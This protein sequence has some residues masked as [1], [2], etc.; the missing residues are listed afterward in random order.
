[1][2]TPNVMRS[3]GASTSRRGSGRG[4]AGSVS[5]SPIV[6][7][8]RPATDDDV[9]RAGLGDV[10][11]VDAVGRLEA[12]HRAGERHGPARLDGPGGV[13]GLLAHDGDPLAGPDRAVPDPPDRHP[14]DVVVRGQVRDE[15]LERVARRR[16]DGGGVTSTSR[17]S[18]GRRSVPGLVEVERVAVPALA[19]V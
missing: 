3:V 13:V 7:S 8:G 11:P 6:T 19:F 14:P 12:G 17:S 4:S 10:D 18:S 15:Q 5:V 2:F 9:A 1:M 16:S